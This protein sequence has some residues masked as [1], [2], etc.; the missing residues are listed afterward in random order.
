MLIYFEK[1]FPKL[2][3]ELTK[4]KNPNGQFFHLSR[5][6][7]LFNTKLTLAKTSFKTSDTH[8][9]QNDKHLQHHCGILFRTILPTSGFQQISQIDEQ[10]SAQLSMSQFCS[11][12]MGTQH[13]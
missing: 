12:F 11:V 6:F 13:A 8:S 1:V 7:I 3:W 9:S 10:D 2:F 4:L 5:M